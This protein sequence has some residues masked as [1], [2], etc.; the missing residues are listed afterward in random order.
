MQLYQP[1]DLKDLSAT[2]NN[3]FQLAPGA[4]VLASN[5]GNTIRQGSI[6]QSTVDLAQSMTELLVTQRAYSLNNRVLQSTDDML[7]TIN[8]FTD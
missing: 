3:T 5:Q 8:R 2:G 1:N 7:S 6:E 4:Q